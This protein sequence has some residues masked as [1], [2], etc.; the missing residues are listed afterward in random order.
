MQSKYDTE[1]LIKDMVGD[2]KLSHFQKK[3]IMESYKY[4]SSLPSTGIAVSKQKSIDDAMLSYKLRQKEEN[5]FPDTNR[6]KF[7]TKKKMFEES[8]FQKEVFRPSPTVD[9]DREK[10]ILATYNEFG[11]RKNVPQAVLKGRIDK[12]IV[13]S[14][15]PVV[16]QKSRFEEIQ[17]EID[18]RVQ[19]IEHME[20]LGPMDR[21]QKEIILSQIDDY[22]RELDS[23]QK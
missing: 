10:N 3:E 19:F 21:R 18:E 7:T 12:Q 20:K 9:R 4:K 6:G 23:L 8:L 17:E 13:P 1:K 16:K 5:I 2:A 11:G 22:I 15:K 14:N